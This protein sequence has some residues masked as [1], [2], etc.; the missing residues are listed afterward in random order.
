MCADINCTKG[1]DINSMEYY[2]PTTKEWTLSSS[3]L[4]VA[5]AGLQCVSLTTA[6]VCAGPPNYYVWHG[7]GTQWETV[8]QSVYRIEMGYAAV[9]GRWAVFAGGEAQPDDHSKVAGTRMDVYDSVSKKWSTGLSLSSAKKKLACGSGGTGDDTVV[10]AGGFAASGHAGYMDTVD[11]F[12]L[13]SMTK[14]PL[15][16]SLGAKRMFLGAGGAAHKVVVAGGLN[17]PDKSTQ[18][19]VDV[20]DTSTM[21]MHSK[22]AQLGAHRYF[23]TSATVMNRFV[24]FGP[25]MGGKFPVATLAIDMYDTKTDF[26]YQGGVNPALPMMSAMNANGAAGGACSFWA[27]G[28]ARSLM[29]H[30]V[31]N[32]VEMYCVSGC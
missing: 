10:C 2:D 1:T 19:V 12:N 17:A 3:S 8:K 29:Y 23:L 22:A 30:S 18:Y 5:H 16:A 20:L 9:S 14:V 11:V 7:P 28:G 27:N 15:K 25:G 32:T 13:T 6:V 4:P 24:F 31:A 26:M 21:T